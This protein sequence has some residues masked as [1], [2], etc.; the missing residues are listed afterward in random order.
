MLATEGTSVTRPVSPRLSSRMPSRISRPISLLV[1]AI[2]FFLDSPEDVRGDVFGFVLCID[3]QHPDGASVKARV[4]DDAYS[5]TLTATRLAPSKLP[6]AARTLDQGSLLG[7]TGQLELKLGILLV[8]EI[9]A[10]KVREESRLDECVHAQYTS[11]TDIREMSGGAPFPTPASGISA[12]TGA[13]IQP[14]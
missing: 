3:G 6:D 12:R 5:A 8:G 4:I 13:I 2:D 10:D 9:P 11:V 14:R 1:L 7:V